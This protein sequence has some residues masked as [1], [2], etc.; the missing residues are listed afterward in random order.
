MRS[1]AGKVVRRLMKE[2]VVMALDRWQEYVDEEKLMRSKAGKVVRRLMKEGV[3]MAFDRWRE[4]VFEELLHLPTEAHESNEMVEHSQSESNEDAEPLQ[5]AVADVVE[6]EAVQGASSE[7]VEEAT[8]AINYDQ[9]ATSESEVEALPRE[10][11]QAA[12]QEEARTQVLSVAVVAADKLQLTRLLEQFCLED[13]ADVLASNGIKKYRDLSFIDDD[14]INELTLTTVSK[15]KLR[16][17]VK[18]LGAPAPV[19]EETL[20]LV[21]EAGDYR[22]LR[23]ADEPCVWELGTGKLLF[24]RASS[25][26]RAG[27]AQRSS[28]CPCEPP[29]PPDRKAL[30]SMPSSPSSLLRSSLEARPLSCHTVVSGNISDEFLVR[31]LEGPTKISDEFLA[32]LLEGP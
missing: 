6:Q 21:Q 28:A 26:G 4:N 25:G 12:I 27:E 1:K 8:A 30:P 16:K 20:E 31:L 19:P 18:A 24:S 10:V 7:T 15:A 11:E 9:A 29:R 32:D 2:G 13:E 17:L 22:E 3:V 5:E 23:D 14:V